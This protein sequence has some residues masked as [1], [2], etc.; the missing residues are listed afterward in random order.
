MLR[1]G[2]AADHPARD[3]LTYLD[4]ERTMKPGDW[5]WWSKKSTAINYSIVGAVLL[6]MLWEALRRRWG[7]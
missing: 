6:I 4:Q 5:P 3:Q 2:L 7:F 1:S